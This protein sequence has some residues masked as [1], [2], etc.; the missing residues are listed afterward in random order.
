MVMMIVLASVVVMPRLCWC[1]GVRGGVGASVWGGGGGGVVVGVVAAVVAAAVVAAAV[2]VLQV[3]HLLA[4]EAQV[5]VAVVAGQ[6]LLVRLN[7]LFYQLILEA[8]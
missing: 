6:Y 7:Y 3:L 2:V 5:V 4:L 1:G 8:A